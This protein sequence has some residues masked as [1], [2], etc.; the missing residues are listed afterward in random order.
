MFISKWNMLYY[1]SAV[2]CQR[3]CMRLFAPY[4]PNGPSNLS[5]WEREK[6]LKGG[7]GVEGI[8]GQLPK[9]CGLSA[10]V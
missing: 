5:N 8:F 7:G 6:M 9:L 4:L 3:I 10:A 2:E 1:S